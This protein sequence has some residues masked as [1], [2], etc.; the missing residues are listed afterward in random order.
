MYI[1]KSPLLPHFLSSDYF[2]TIFFYSSL[3]FSFSYLHFALFCAISLTTV[4]FSLYFPAYFSPSPILLFLSLSLSPTITLFPL[5]FFQ[6]FYHR[7][8]FKLIFHSFITPTSVPSLSSP[9][10]LV[11]LYLVFSYCGFFEPRFH[12]LNLFSLDSC[13]CYQICLKPAATEDSKKK[14]RESERE[15]NDTNLSLS[16]ISSVISFPMIFYFLSV[17]FDIRCSLKV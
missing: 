6:V 7:Y 17:R 2:P 9:T 4:T 10:S 11:L 12:L 5:H 16:L 8:Y 1:K 15:I 14:E 3:H 13:D